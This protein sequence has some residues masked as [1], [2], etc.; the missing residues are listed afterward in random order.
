MAVAIENARLFAGAQAALAEIGAMK[1]LMENV[2][3]SITS[4]VITTDAADRVRTYNAAAARI[5]RRPAERAL[6]QPLLDVLPPLGTAFADQLRAVR[7]GGPDL[8]LEA[9]A[10]L[11]DH[12]P[13]V[14]SL[15]LSPLTDAG[16]PRPG[17]ALVLDDLTAAREREQM[18]A[19]VRRY[20]PPGLIDNLDA[21]SQL[22]L[23]GARREVTCLFAE[24]GARAAFP[25]DLA[26]AQV[27]ERLNRFLTR[28]TEAVH[29]ADGLIDK[30][31]GREL[32]AL[33]NSPLNPQPDH[34]AR[35]VRAALDLCQALGGPDGPGFR[36]GIH[37]G[38]A[39]LGNVGS[40]NRRN[41]TAIGDTINLAKRLLER[42]GEG[43]ILISDAARQALAAAGDPPAGAH[44]IARGG[45]QAR[46][47]QQ[48]TVVYEVQAGR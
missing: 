37:S 17:V 26:P 42:A 44:V 8:A 5:L 35:A 40:A 21:I 47:R 48:V 39:T 36:V 4:G 2:F 28:A 34:A 18:L 10:D 13:A 12:G 27:M 9:T 41:Y 25:D 16:Q 32:M 30:Y 43:Q 20:L 29:R 11:P 1:E 7:D 3:A 31:N 23:G 19:Q 45:L 22:A 24:I 15:K 46:G 6:G 33:F 14:L 38:V